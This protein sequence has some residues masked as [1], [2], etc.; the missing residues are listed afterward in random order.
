MTPA[1]QRSLSWPANLLLPGTGLVLMRREWLGLALAM[2][3]SISG[4]VVIAGRWIAPATVPDWMSALALLIGAAT[5]CL[6]QYLLW[7]QR[8][9]MELSSQRIATILAEARRAIE[10]GNLAS[11]LCTLNIGAAIDDEHLELQVLRAR[12]LAQTG[13]RDASCKLWRWIMK[14]Q[15][16]GRYAAEAENA[17]G[18]R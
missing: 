14:L 16:A 18:A 11:A 1:W 15:D 6:S 4:N 17:L 8:R 12:V 3:F 13:D 10:A 5:W 2:V 7:R 9:T